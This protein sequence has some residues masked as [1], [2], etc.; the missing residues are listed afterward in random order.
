MAEKPAQK[1]T[2]YETMDEEELIACC[3]NGDLEAFNILI[4][5]HEERVL[6]Q[7]ARYLTDYQTAVEAAQEIFIKVFKKI[8][9]FKGESSFKTWLYKITSNHCLN[10]IEKRKRQYY[11]QHMSLNG[12]GD[13]DPPLQQEDL[14]SKRADEILEDKQLAV[15]VH[16]AIAHLPQDQQQLIILR[17]YEELS[18]EEIAQIMKI[19]ASTVCSGLYR[20]RQRLKQIIGRQ[21]GQS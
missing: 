4:S 14:R 7:A 10:V 3:Q 2:A 11:Y 1:N 16:D 18:Y 19:P 13:K 21:G 15:A 6:N 17:H 8:N 9:M 12:Q 5:R 20:A